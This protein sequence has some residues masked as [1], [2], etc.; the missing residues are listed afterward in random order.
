MLRPYD[1]P[2]QPLRCLLYDCLMYPYTL[3]LATL[4]LPCLLSKRAVCILADLWLAGFFFLNRHVLGIKC[5][6]QPQPLPRQDGTRGV[7]IAAKH[8]SA[9]E[10]LAL[11]R[12]YPQAVMVA[13]REL[14]LL[15]FGWYMWRIGFIPL[16]RG[17][18]AKALKKLI[19]AVK[20]RLD[21]GHDVI[22][23]P[24][25][26]RRVVGAPP[27]YKTGIYGLYHHAEVTVLPLALNSGHVWGCRPLYRQPGEVSI[28]VAEP[29]TVG[30]N[31]QDF[32][33]LLQ[34]R[35]ETAYQALPDP[36]HTPADA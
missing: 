28:A 33:H 17:G 26:T 10:T 7:L 22:I 31:K 20:K 14:F 36:R 5:H 29:I 12:Y 34:Q 3:V 13:K 2:V 27:A 21:E 11:R 1:R 30:L 8:Q 9:W 15:P 4:G 25:G 23:F 32:M 6:F 24:E 16:N 18:H 35:I 19:C